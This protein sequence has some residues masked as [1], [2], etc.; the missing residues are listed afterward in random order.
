[1]R[2]DKEYQYPNIPI[3]KNEFVLDNKILYHPNIMNNRVFA[4]FR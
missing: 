1:M 2:F 4:V 3:L